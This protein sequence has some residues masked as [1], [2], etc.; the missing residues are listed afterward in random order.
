MLLLRRLDRWQRRQQCIDATIRHPQ[1]RGALCVRH[2]ISGVFSSMHCANIT[3]LLSV[4][5]SRSGRVVA[6]LSDS[7]CTCLPSCRQRQVAGACVRA[8][9]C[10]AG[11]PHH[12]A[13]CADLIRAEAFQHWA[14]RER[15]R[16]AAPGAT[17]KWSTAAAATSVLRSRC[18]R[19]MAAGALFSKQRQRLTVS[20]LFGSVWSKSCCSQA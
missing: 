20:A 7:A 4:L 2:V 13:G 6:V 16:C 14:G 11:L 10:C 12:M 15:P 8:G 9:L 18:K 17:C 19:C 5:G 1:D 3:R